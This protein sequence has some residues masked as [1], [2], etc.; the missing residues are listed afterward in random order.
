MGAFNTHTQAREFIAGLVERGPKPPPNQRA[1]DDRIRSIGTERDYTNTAK[2][3][4]GWMKKHKY[5]TLMRMT[6]RQANEYLEERAVI[7]GQKTL[8][9][10]RAVLDRLPRTGKAPL[11]YVESGVP[12][13]HLAS[14]SRAYEHQPTRNRDEPTT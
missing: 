1:N 4:A 11:D 5:G 8:D 9:R 10:D 3:I 6:R 2:N 7:V 13:G 14:G 12:P